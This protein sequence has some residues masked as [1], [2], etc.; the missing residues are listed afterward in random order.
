M[1]F[2]EAYTGDRT[3]RKSTDMIIVEV[4]RVDREGLNMRRDSQEL[5]GVSI[6]YFLTLVVVLWGL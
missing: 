5:L 6:F 4:R 1:I 2:R 3:T